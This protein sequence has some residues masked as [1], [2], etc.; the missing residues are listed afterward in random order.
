[1]TY[2]NF[3]KVIP[4]LKFSDKASYYG[5]QIK[6]KDIQYLANHDDDNDHIVDCNADLDYSLSSKAMCK[7]FRICTIENFYLQENDAV[8]RYLEGGCSGVGA[9]CPG[10]TSS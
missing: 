3:Q 9:I 10:Q 4:S 8:R 2:F 5:M 6:Y 7:D 1:M